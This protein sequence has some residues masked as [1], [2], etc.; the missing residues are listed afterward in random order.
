MVTWW[1]CKSGGDC[2]L[3]V[4]ALKRIYI[5]IYLIYILYIY[6]YFFVC[7]LCAMNQVGMWTACYVPPACMTPSWEGASPR[8]PAQLNAA[9]RF[10][11]THL[12]KLWLLRLRGIFCTSHHNRT[13]RWASL[14]LDYA[15]ASVVECESNLSGFQRANPQ[16]PW[17]F[18]GL[19]WEGTSL[20]S[21]GRSPCP[22]GNKIGIKEYGT[23]Q[24][25]PPIPHQSGTARERERERTT[26]IQ[27]FP[28]VSTRTWRRRGSSIEPGSSLFWQIVG[29]YARN[30]ALIIIICFNF[31]STIFS[32]K[33]YSLDS[34]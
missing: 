13:W 23:C 22:I 3:T 9:W 17:E 18:D 4:F 5:Y 15:V 2:H 6:I 10:T 11:C 1:C 24:G 20:G 32:S 8:S 33:H 19:W 14:G 26:R 31:T 12:H 28:A 7:C 27:H 21:L 16:Q 29:I 34:I 30:I 25:L